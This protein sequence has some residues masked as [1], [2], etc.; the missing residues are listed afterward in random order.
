MDKQILFINHDE[1]QL[2]MLSEIAKENNW[3]FDCASNGVDAAIL[4]KQHGYQLV[5]TGMQL[6]GYD[7]EK[8]ITFIN[9]SFPDTPIIVY[10]EILTA[11]QLFFLYNDRK[12]WRTLLYTTMPSAL[13]SD[14][15]SDALLQ[16]GCQ[17]LARENNLARLSL[18]QSLQEQLSD[19]TQAL[20]AFDAQNDFSDSFLEKLLIEANKL[21][22]PYYNATELSCLISYE[23]E[24]RLIFQ[25]RSAPLS[26]F[27][28]IRQTLR[29]NFPEENGCFLKIDF[30]EMANFYTEECNERV[31]SLIAVYLL[32]WKKIYGYY[33]GT[34]A[35]EI[36]SANTIRIL[37]RFDLDHEKW[38]QIMAKKL[39]RDIFL[40]A[41]A[42]ARFFSADFSRELQAQDVLLAMELSLVRADKSPTGA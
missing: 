21:L 4:L 16:Y 9:H 6:S 24:L 18:R 31:Y 23:K 29:D 42:I 22:L 36:R 27:R 7:G 10:T 20:L 26:D 13:L 41:D 1:A 12:I 33:Q 34:A 5:V 2:Q 8:I 15:F 14:V 30:P 28:S 40:L 39:H 11:A 19:L 38:E 32:T 3:V 17:K 35:I 37:L 25:R